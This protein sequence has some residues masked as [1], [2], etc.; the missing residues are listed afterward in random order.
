[1][2]ITRNR[3]ILYTIVIIILTLLVNTSKVEASFADFTDEQAD[4]QAQEQIKEQEKE[5][6][7]TEVKSSDNYLIN[8]QIDGYKLTPEFDK[9]TL[10][11]T[12]DGELKANEIN[13]KATPSNEKATINGAGTV[14][15]EENKNEYRIDVTAENGSVRTY[16]IKLKETQKADQGKNNG[17]EQI[18]QNVEQ[19]NSKMENENTDKN[20]SNEKNSSNVVLYTI[21]AVLFIIILVL[22][23]VIMR[24]RKKS[25][26]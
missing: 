24:K 17:V 1:M 21:I 22:V 14:K 15:V 12:I 3:L 16:I 9:Q 10:E 11:Y 18:E 4:K 13:I 6:N 23:I 25:K 8:L 20:L 2:K 5:H 26:H 19:N 7:I